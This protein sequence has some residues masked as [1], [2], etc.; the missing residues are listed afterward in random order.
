MHTVVIA[1]V[2]MRARVRTAGAEA[3][4]HVK[5]L[6]MRYGGKGEECSKNAWFIA[7]TAG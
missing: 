2:P 4:K 1:G 3:G 5:H 7:C 6:M